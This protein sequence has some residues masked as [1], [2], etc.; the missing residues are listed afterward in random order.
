MEAVFEVPKSEVLNAALEEQGLEPCEEGRLLIKRVFTAA[1]ANRQF[2]N[3]SAATLAVLKRLGDELVD[4][5][6][7]H[8]HQSLLAADKQLELL[9]AF[10]GA[11]AARRAYEEQYRRLR[12]LEA[13][14][15]GLAADE[16]ALERELDLLRHQVH[17]IEAAPPGA[18]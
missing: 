10:A 1:G 17:E 12:A 9:D 4:L 16:A 11:G 3:G 13:E 2:I 6:G 15:D 14:R 18:G 7:P 5:H 8:D